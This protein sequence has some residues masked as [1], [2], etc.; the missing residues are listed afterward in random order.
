VVDPGHE[1]QEPA[2]EADVA[3]QPGALAADGILDHLHQDLLALLHGGEG[4][5]RQ[6]E[7]GLD[8]VPLV[9]LGDLLAGQAVGLRL[10]EVQEPVLGAPDGHEGALHPLEELGDAPLVDI[11]H[12]A[13]LGGALYEQLA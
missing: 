12:L 8:A 3:A 9:L 1:H 11:P 13:D 5:G 4:D 2:R 10:I 6:G 7:L